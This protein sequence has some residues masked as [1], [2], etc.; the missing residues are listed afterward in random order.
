[1]KA[2]YYLVEQEYETGQVR[3]V[4]GRQM[5][6]HQG[7]RASAAIVSGCLFRPKERDYPPGAL[8]PCVR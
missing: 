8:P 1:M 3:P 4:T 6:L 5:T 7:R 2:V